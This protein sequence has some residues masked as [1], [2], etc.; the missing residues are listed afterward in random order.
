MVPSAFVILEAL[1]R[2]PNDKVD[3]RA[4]PAPDKSRPELEEAFVAPRTDTEQALAAMF[5]EVLGVER[6]GANDNFFELGG[7]SL[8]ATQIVSRIRESF[9]T[10]LSLQRF[11]DAPTVA[12]LAEAITENKP[13]ESS[14]NLITKINRENERAI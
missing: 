10:D 11:F 14:I 2:T 9:K 7:H 4:L 3:R 13:D 8:L 12:R 1:P 5:S 6:V